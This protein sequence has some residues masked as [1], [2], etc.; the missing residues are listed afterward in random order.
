MAARN[1]LPRVI[2]GVVV[3]AIVLVL[4]WYPPLAVGFTI[5]VT[6]MA[7]I[8]LYEYYALVRA[9]AISPE[10]IGGILAGIMVTVSGAFGDLTLTSFLLYGGSL[11]VAA[12]HVVRGQHSVA[13]LATSVFGVFYVGWFAAHFVFL[14]NDPTMGPGWIMVLLVAVVLT[15]TGAYFVGSLL[16]RHKMA[17]KVSPNKTWEGAAG[18]LALAIAGMVG[19]WALNDVTDTAVFPA[20]K[21]EVYILTGA[22]LSVASQIGDLAESC[23]KRDA[24]VK[25]SGHIFPGHGGVLDRCDGFL[26][27]APVLYYIAKPLV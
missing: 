11:L 22:L 9:R 8:G 4:V 25:D 26:F 17:P 16:G 27:A 24:G 3:L 5:F 7:A 1:L 15:D 13:G 21:L 12:L 19:V 18:G 23:L 6:A 20:W 10:T 14:R 2:T